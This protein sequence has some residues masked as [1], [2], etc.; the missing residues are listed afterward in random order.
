MNHVHYYYMKTLIDFV[1]CCAYL[2]KCKKKLLSNYE[3]R[4][5]CWSYAFKQN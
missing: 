3:I 5:C 2:P 4:A 1:L